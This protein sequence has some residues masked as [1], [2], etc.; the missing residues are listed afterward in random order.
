MTHGEC[1]YILESEGASRPILEVHDDDGMDMV[2]V[3]I[4][5]D[6]I[7]MNFNCTIKDLSE[8]YFT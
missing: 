8:M 3:I 1:N 2:L 7:I 6:V 5:L 4:L